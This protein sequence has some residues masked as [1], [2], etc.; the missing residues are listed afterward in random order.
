MLPCPDTPDFPYP[1]NRWIFQGQCFPAGTVIHSGTGLFRPDLLPDLPHAQVQSPPSDRQET[2]CLPLLNRCRSCSR[3]EFQPCLHWKMPL[4]EAFRLRWYPHSVRL[5]ILHP[6]QWRSFHRGTWHHSGA[7]RYK[8][9]HPPRSNGSLPPH[10]SDFLLHRALQGPHKYWIGFLSFL[11]QQICV[12][13][14][15]PQC[16][17]EFLP[18]W[19]LP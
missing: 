6:L 10:R 11:P 7:W 16:P 12:G 4:P 3:P 14:D 9:F 8:H 17:E 5:N 2:R 1:S 18:W 13:Q 19:N 15:Y